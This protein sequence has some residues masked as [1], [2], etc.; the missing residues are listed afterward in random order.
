M[1]WSLRAQ[2]RSKD[3]DRS[4]E[5]SACY[6]IQMTLACSLLVSGVSAA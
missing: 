3:M 1:S 5:S 2:L 4:A 6:T